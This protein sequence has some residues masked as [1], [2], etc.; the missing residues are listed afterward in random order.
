LENENGEPSGFSVDLIKEVM[1]RLHYQYT[2]KLY[3]RKITLAKARTGHG[4]II[5]GMTYTNE[6]AKF[7]KFGLVYDYAFK[8][9]AFR[10]DEKPIT[11]FEQ[12]KGKRVAAEHHSYA[13]TL[14]KKA[15]FPVII[16]PVKNL[17]DAFTM[18]NSHQVDAVLCNHAV[19]VYI[20]E[21]G[22][23]K[24]ISHA[25]IKLPLEKYCLCG[26]NE[27]LLTKINFVI[28]D[29]K[30]EGVYDKLHDK[31]FSRRQDHILQ[32]HHPCRT[33]INGHPCPFI[34]GVLHPAQLQ[35]EKKRKRSW[36]ANQRNL[37]ISLHAGQ[38]GI[39]GY[40]VEKKDFS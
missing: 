37:D 19:A 24:N 40:D 28:Y 39:W 38:I 33:I 13:E 1:K 12:F 35:S 17:V 2:I 34:F 32:T 29:L 15:K 18:L 22:N 36:N 27:E 31:W 4:D 3:P 20:I 16:V 21:K 5:L 30:R 10:N 11:L 23:F 14:L 25:D 8:D 26:T 6:R 7:L 9:A